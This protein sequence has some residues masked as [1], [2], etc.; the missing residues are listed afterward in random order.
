MVLYKSIVARKKPSTEKEV[1]AYFRDNERIKG[2]KLKSFTVEL[3]VF[4]TQMDNYT[5]HNNVHA[6]HYDLIAVFE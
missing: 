4:A 5:N 2:K 6:N 3:D 1:I